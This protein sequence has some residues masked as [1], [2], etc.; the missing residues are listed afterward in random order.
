[1]SDVALSDGD[2]RREL[3]IVRIDDLDVD[4]RYQRTLNQ[5]LVEEI[6]EDWDK[7]DT[8]VLTVSRRKN[9]K[10]FLVNGQHRAA[11]AKL[12]GETE[13]L[14]FVYDGLTVRQ[15]ADLRLKSN[16][17]RADTSLERFWA[18]VTAG[19]K[20]SKDI[21]KL[22]EEFGTH[23][24]KTPN[25][26]TGVNCIS[27]VEALFREDEE[28]LRQTLHAIREAHVEIGGEAAKVP[29]LRGTYWFL[30]VHAGDY[31]LRSLIERMRLHGPEDLM[32][33]ARAFKAINGGPDWINYYRS[34]LEAYNYRRAEHT[35]LEMRT[36]YHSTSEERWNKKTA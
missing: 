18:R 9:G 1:V 21:V 31:H 14:A 13:M 23:V 35:R 30:K 5:R 15:E 26:H 10:L 12:K 11:A 3:E 29:V 4:H 22:M 27:A 16:H 32:R 19:R 25:Q 33:K 36:K 2:R 24:N 28:L 34:L 7:V 6:V 20:E 17:G 8:D